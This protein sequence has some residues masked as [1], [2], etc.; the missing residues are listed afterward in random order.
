MARPT[1]ADGTGISGLKMTIR[2][3]D[4]LMAPRSIVLVGASEQ[5]GSVGE[6]VTRNILKAGFDG[7]IWLVNPRRGSALGVP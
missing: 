5:P 7:E 3:L 6:V 1:E 4:R 2:N